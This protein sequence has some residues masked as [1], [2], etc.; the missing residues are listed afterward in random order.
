MEKVEDAIRNKNS[1]LCIG[2]NLPEVDLSDK[3]FEAPVYFTGA[4]F[5]EGANFSSTKFSVAYFDGAKF[6]SIAYFNGA[7]FH[8]AYFRFAEFSSEAYFGSANFSSMVDF[9]EVKFS[10][11]TIFNET[12]FLGIAFFDYV[13]FLDAVSFVNSDFSPDVLEKCLDPYNYI[14]FRH[15]NFE[16]QEKVVFDGCN[17]ERVSFICTDIE[18]VKFRNV[19]WRDFK[20]YDEKLFLLKHLE[21]ERKKFVEDGKIKLKEISKVSNEKILEVLEGK[22]KASETEEEIVKAL[23]SRIP[24]VLKEINQLENKKEK[25]EDEED[26]LNKLLKE[27]ENKIDEIK[28]EVEEVI[29]S[30][31]EEI[32]KNILENISEDEDLTLD[33]VLAVYRALR[34]NYDYYLKYDESGKILHQ[35]NEVKEKVF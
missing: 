15:S 32:E 4:I 13:A 34:E 20:I 2:Y 1:L 23:E 6:S 25:T 10:G 11:A 5:H 33:N 31:D 24:D 28:S 19:E 35:R 16:K 30:K 21:K 3:K 9:R 27:C 17:M 7:I 29:S 18:R 12:K 14:S 22:R 8:E 26:K